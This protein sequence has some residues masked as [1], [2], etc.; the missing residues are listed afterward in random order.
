[1]H[2]DGWKANGVEAGSAAR[3]GTLR[4]L[5]ARR[6]PPCKRLWVSERQKLGRHAM[7]EREPERVV[8]HLLLRSL[9]HLSCIHLYIYRCNT[10]AK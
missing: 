6:S 4:E 1:M 9:V 2:G 8:H 7:I 10:G 5:I 3:P